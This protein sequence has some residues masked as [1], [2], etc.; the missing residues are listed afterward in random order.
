LKNAARGAQTDQLAGLLDD[1]DQLQRSAG[2]NLNLHMALENVLLRLREALGAA[3]ATT[4][5]R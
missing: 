2:R 5:A 1:I 3:P 4:P